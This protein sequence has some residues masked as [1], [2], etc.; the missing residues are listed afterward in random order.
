[1][2]V[3]RECREYTVDVLVNGLE[4]EVEFWTSC[5][6]G[7]GV[8]TIVVVKELTVWCLLCVG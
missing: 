8:A 5:G 3:C 6:Y 2:V 1:M 7:E 4:V